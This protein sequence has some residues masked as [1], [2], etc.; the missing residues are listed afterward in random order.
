ARLGAHPC[1]IPMLILPSPLTFSP[2]P[3]MAGSLPHLY[4]TSS[5]PVLPFCSRSSQI[6]SPSSF[7]FFFPG[8][9]HPIMWGCSRAAGDLPGGGS[10]L[11]HSGGGGALPGRSGGDPPPGELHDGSDV[12]PR[13]AG[14]DKLP[15]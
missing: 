8:D 5:L 2:T 11:A 7:P 6:Q 12:L 9:G 15:T 14:V 1:T 10:A 4:P 13:G 3:H